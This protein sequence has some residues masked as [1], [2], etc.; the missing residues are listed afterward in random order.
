MFFVNQENERH[1]AFGT[2]PD[3][4]VMRSESNCLFVRTKHAERHT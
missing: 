3:M 2:P 4:I 1:A